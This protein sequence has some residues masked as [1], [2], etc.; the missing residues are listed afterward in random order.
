MPG[1]AVS[2]KRNWGWDV[3]TRRRS[4]D[5]D[6]V[7]ELL[8]VGLVRLTEPVR[9]STQE[10]GS[11]SLREEFSGGPKYA[12]ESCLIREKVIAPV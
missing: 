12:F 7:V 1:M 11:L 10:Y 6:E 3:Q 4:L 8:D 5:C 2:S 9:H